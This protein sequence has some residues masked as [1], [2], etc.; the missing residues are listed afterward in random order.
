MLPNYEKEKKNNY[1]CIL[2][3]KIPTCHRILPV[4]LSTTSQTKHSMH[5][6]YSSLPSFSTQSGSFT[7][8][9]S[10][11]SSPLLSASFLSLYM[12][13]ENIGKR[14]RNQPKTSVDFQSDGT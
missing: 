12:S 10:F 13:M 8:S 2:F 14:P 1:N 6:F 11:F 9:F 7:I 5:A 4:A 3:T